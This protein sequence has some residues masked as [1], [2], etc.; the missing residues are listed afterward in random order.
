MHFTTLI[1]IAFLTL[2]SATQPEPIQEI[3]PSAFDFSKS[4]LS[5]QP[6]IQQDLQQKTSNTSVEVAEKN[7]VRTRIADLPTLNGECSLVVPSPSI[8]NENGRTLA[9]TTSDDIFYSKQG[10]YTV[11][12]QYDD[13]N[14]TIL[15]Q[16]QEVV[17]KDV[18]AL[19]PEA[20]KL[21][22][23][24]GDCMV[25]ISPPAAFDNCK[26]RVFAKTNDPLIYDQ[27][28]EYSV[29]WVFEDGNGNATYQEQAVLVQDLISPL[30]TP[31]ADLTIRIEEREQFAIAEN[32][33][34]P[35]GSDNCSEV[36]ISNNAPSYFEVG[37][38]EVIWTSTD[39]NGNTSQAI[40][41]ITVIASVPRNGLENNRF[42][43]QGELKPGEFQLFPNP[44]ISETNLYV[45]MDQE[46]DV[47]IELFDGAG[48]LVYERSIRRS[49]TF[50]YQI[51]V[52]NLS[53]GVYQVQVSVGDQIMSKRLIKK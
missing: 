7:A 4:E 17:I 32:L 23:I 53:A 1:A 26:G 37:I 21:P 49:N 18:S 29:L 42:A 28:G 30:I 33:G 8:A 35:L 34:T 14:G 31:P 51:P 3:L 22:T 15:E 24:R 9:A 45:G 27:P 48:R 52:N 43:I 20:V 38:T 47:K 25:T 44:A 10:S 11:T 41:K 5:A 2:S 46:A 19:T 50:E 6:Q 16:K 13:G 40:Q 12:W 39:G 36:V